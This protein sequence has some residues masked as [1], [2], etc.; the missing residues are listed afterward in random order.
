ML[1][2]END[3]TIKEAAEHYHPGYDDK[4]WE[5]MEQLLDE[6]LPQKKRKKKD[7]FHSSISVARGYSC[8]FYCDE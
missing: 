3:K 2:D 7:L 5:K 4:A 1:D 6:H 8:V